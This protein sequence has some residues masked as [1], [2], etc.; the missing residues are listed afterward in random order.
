[1]AERYV[2]DVEAPGSSPGTPTTPSLCLPYLL[3]F[4]FWLLGKF[5]RT[6]TIETGEYTVV[7]LYVWA[8]SESLCPDMGNLSYQEAIMNGFAGKVARIDLTSKSVR[9]EPLDAEVARKY[10]GG[11]AFGAKVL[12]EELEP[13]TDPL[14]PDNKLIFVGGPAT[15]T[16]IPGQTRYLVIGKSPLT[17]LYGEAGG[18]GAFMTMVKRAGYDALIV[19]GKAD[20]PV[21]LWIHDGQV[22]IRDAGHVWGQLVGDTDDA[23]REEVG[24][25]NARVACI[26]PAG[27]KQV[28]FAAIIAEKFKAAGRC[29]L[30]A[31]MGSKNLKAIVARGTGNVPIA[32]SAK[33]RGIIREMVEAARENPG[34]QSMGKYG[35]S[36]HLRKSA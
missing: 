22:E 24:D 2:R 17:G 25:P 10:E 36:T 32:N 15:G 26:G 35:P 34:Q 12:L 11:R 3:S 28:K 1:M 14:G 31:V 23:L 13:E 18:G 16:V 27:E 29:G 9:E 33:L 4:S 8:A 20:S 19:E 21:Y 30:G 5:G 7:A 6:L